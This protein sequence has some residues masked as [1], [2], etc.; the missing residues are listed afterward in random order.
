M[1]LD[2]EIVRGI[3]LAMEAHPH[4]F[5]PPTIELD[6][7]TQEQIGY[8]VM[9]MAQAG[10]VEGHSTTH[11]G[12]RSP[13]WAARNLTWA[14]HQFIEAAREESRWQKAKTQVKDKTGALSFELVKR[15][16]YDLMSG[17]VFPG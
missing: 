4:G 3:L 16:L 14:G 13:S 11:H 10:L 7:Y 9:L 6:G 12:S 5:A 1:K 15:L 2:M 8:H 17:A